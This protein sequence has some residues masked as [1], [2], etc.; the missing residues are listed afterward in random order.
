MA[1]A[2]AAST[3][4]SKEGGRARR[5]PPWTSGVDPSMIPRFSWYVPAGEKSGDAFWFD[6]TRGGRRHR[7]HTVDHRG[8]STRDKLEDLMEHIR[9]LPLDV[10]REVG[11]A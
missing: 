3:S 6:A 11:F 9:G 1:R 10:R 5:V 2:A 7:W 4:S 8:R